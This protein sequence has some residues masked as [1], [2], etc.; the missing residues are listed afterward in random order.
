MSISSILTG[1]VIL[2]L[3]TVLVSF[4]KKPAF[5]KVHLKKNIDDPRFLMVFFPVISWAIYVKFFNLNYSF[6]VESPKIITGLILGIILSFFV[7]RKT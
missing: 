3:I 1:A 6:F 4:S 2:V 7:L 5:P